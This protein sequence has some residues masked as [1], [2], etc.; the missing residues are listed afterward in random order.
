L[1][2]GIFLEYFSPIGYRWNQFACLFYCLEMIFWCMISPLVTP[3]SSSLHVFVS[4]SLFMRFIKNF[5][6]RKWTT[7]PMEKSLKE[8][9]Q[10]HWYVSN[11]SIIF[12]APCLFL[13][14]LLSVS[15]HFVAFLCIFWN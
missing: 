9:H 13:H 8:K 4:K 15:L 7:T 6:K 11:V 3:Y 12:D 2:S 1:F 5:R 10:G 14:H